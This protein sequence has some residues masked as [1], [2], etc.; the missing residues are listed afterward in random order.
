MFERTFEIK[1]LLAMKCS[2]QILL[3][4]VLFQ[5]RGR[6]HPQSGATPNFFLEYKCS[7]LVLSNEVLFVSRFFWK[8]LENQEKEKVIKRPNVSNWRKVYINFEIEIEH[9]LL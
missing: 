7:I 2:R 1:R 5:S 6:G 8:I 4:V 3:E 9:F